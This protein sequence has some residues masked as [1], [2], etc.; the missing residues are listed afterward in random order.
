MYVHLKELRHVL[1]SSHLQYLFSSHFSRFS[2]RFHN[3]NIYIARTNVKVRTHLHLE[4]SRYALK[5]SVTFF[6]HL[7]LYIYIFSLFF[8]IYRSANI[9]DDVARIDNKVQKCSH[10][11]EL[12]R[13]RA[14]VPD[15]F[16]FRAHHLRAALCAAENNSEQFELRSVPASSRRSSR[17]ESSFRFARRARVSRIGGKLAAAIAI[18]A[19]Q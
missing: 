17:S 3:A 11:E 8:S 15:G 7:F 6:L 12:R 18:Y 16:Q 14:T 9:I 13:A 10:L 1:L 4:E 2:L 5:L 19:D